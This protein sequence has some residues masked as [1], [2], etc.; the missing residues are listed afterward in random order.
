M[1]LPPVLRLRC[2]TRCQGARAWTR[3]RTLASPSPRYPVPASQAF[4]VY[5]T[6]R[7]ALP[8]AWYHTAAVTRHPVTA[9]QPH[10]CQAYWPVY[11]KA[12]SLWDGTWP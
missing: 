1:Q 8:C 3:C 7:L 11:T 2:L 9:H 12:V 6:C 5:P 10:P 4:Q